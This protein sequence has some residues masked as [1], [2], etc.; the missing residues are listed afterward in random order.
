ML[1][2][3]KLLTLSLLLVLV[4][5][6]TA[7]LPK[8]QPNEDVTIADNAIVTN[9]ETQNALSSFNADT[10]QMQFAGEGSQL[11]DLAVDTIL[12]SEPINGLAPAGFLRRVTRKYVDGERV[13]L[14]TELAKLEDV[15]QEGSASLTKRI[16]PSD[17]DSTEILL[18]GVSL[19]FDEELSTQGLTT[20]SFGFNLDF[21]EVIIDLD[22]N[23][24]TKDDQLRLE[25]G[26]DFDPILNLDLDFGFFSIEAF[27]FSV[28]FEQ[29]ADIKL[30]GNFNKQLKE[31][32]EVAKLNLKNSVLWIGPVPVVYSLNIKI[33]IGV[34]GELKARIEVSAEQSATLEV[35]AK[36][37]DNRGWDAI[38]KF[39]F[40]F[41]V[42]P[43]TLEA[44]LKGK[45]YA[46]AEAE[47]LFYGLV[48]PSAFIRPYVEADVVLGRDPFWRLNGGIE[49]GIGFEMP[50]IFDL[51]DY[52]KV[53]GS[54][55]QELMR[56]SNQAPVVDIVLPK[57]NQTIELGDKV[58]MRASVSDVED[59]TSCCVLQ[60]SSDLDGNLASINNYDEYF[61]SEGTRTI[62][63]TAT[64]SKGAIAT[65]TITLKVENS[66]PDVSFEMPTSIQQDVPLFVTGTAIDATD[67]NVACSWDVQA[68]DSFEILGTSCQINV[69][70]KTQGTRTLTLNATDKQGKTASET[71]QVDVTA[72]P[73]N[74]PPELKSIT[75]IAP[76]GKIVRPNEDIA[77]LATLGTTFTIRVEVIDPEGDDFNFA[78]LTSNTGGRPYDAGV[79]KTDAISGIIEYKWE[80]DLANQSAKSAAIAI[81]Y[82]NITVEPAFIFSY[83]TVIN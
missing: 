57:E 64:D 53:L 29:E 73:V 47:L 4:A 40:D 43:P 58:L 56:S 16:R 14:E 1:K 26:F 34:E 7:T 33:L 18:E 52:E 54:T 68:P 12:V 41:D 69:T 46:A 23:T 5:C 28:G 74:L 19:S 45:A 36:Y 78:I 39:D 20:Q 10:G 30:I 80:A 15:I 37:S 63:V 70:F 17:L 51:A 2:I 25:G 22:G 27:K 77:F 42:K 65:D 9:T 72:P 31:E 35:G 50:D 66:A 11:G 76:D 8:Q 81:L 6:S 49:A 62:T 71:V 61:K 38:G 55:K 67:G 44:A 59:G 21:N 13:I 32:L 79:I 82:G 60:W 3:A 75:V 83:T 24:S 48:G